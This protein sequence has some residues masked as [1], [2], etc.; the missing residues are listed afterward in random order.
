MQ[1]ACWLQQHHQHQHQHHSP[2][3]HRPADTSMHA[4]AAVVVHDKPRRARSCGPEHQLDP[5]PLRAAR[6]V[7]RGRGACLVAAAA[8]C[9]AHRAQCAAANQGVDT[10]LQR[11]RHLDTF[12]LALANS[13]CSG[14][15]PVFLWSRYARY[16]A[17][18]HSP[19]PGRDHQQ[20][21]LCAEAARGSV[22][23]GR[24]RACATKQA[25]SVRGWRGPRACASAVS[26]CSG[27]GWRRRRAG[28]TGAGCCLH[29]G[30]GCDRHGQHNRHQ[31]P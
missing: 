13:L 2:T 15:C 9:R 4:A 28:S 16:T 26:C 10:K 21:H 11:R 29:Y 12:V 24:L 31:R 27:P 8:C 30:P 17:R 19:C 5:R 23:K 3:H 7:H 25:C 22:G 18:H 1:T 20:Q 6:P 14:Q